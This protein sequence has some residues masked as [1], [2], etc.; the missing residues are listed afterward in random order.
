MSH[1]LSPGVDIDFSGNESLNCLDISCLSSCMEFCLSLRERERG[2][3]EEEGGGGRRKGRGRGRGRGRERGRKSEREREIH[4][5]AHIPELQR[6]SIVITDIF[7]SLP[8]MG[9]YSL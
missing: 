5:I 4:S 7:Q 1:I 3:G 6:L 2:G 9:C 8:H